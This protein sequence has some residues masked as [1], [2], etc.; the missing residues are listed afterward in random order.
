[1]LTLP[2]RYEKLSMPAHFLPG[3]PRLEAWPP[4]VDLQGA[5]DTF[6]RRTSFC[7]LKLLRTRMRPE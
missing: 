2:L 3:L 7:I 5:D 6:E 4:V 1:M